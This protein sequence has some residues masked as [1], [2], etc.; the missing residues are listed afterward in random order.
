MR[1][2]ILKLLLLVQES[3]LILPI[4]IVSAHPEGFPPPRGRVL[5]LYSTFIPLISLDFSQPQLNN[6]HLNLQS[7]PSKFEYVL[8][9]A[10]FYSPFPLVR[11]HI[12]KYFLARSL[13]FYYSPVNLPAR[14]YFV[15]AAIL[16]L[17][18]AILV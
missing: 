8:H 18:S 17:T 6:Y 14:I 12:A 16:A 2:L 5:A 4:D 1:N 7:L 15:T 11:S 9:F 10:A 3:L 13:K